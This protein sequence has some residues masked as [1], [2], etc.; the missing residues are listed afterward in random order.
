M[1]E[2]PFAVYRG[3]L[4][5]GDYPAAEFLQGFAMAM[6]AGGAF[7]MDAG[8]LRRLDDKHLQVF[9]EMASYFRRHGEGDPDFVDV[10]QAIKAKRAAHALFVKQR[11]DELRGSDPDAF[12]GGRHEHAQYLG[13]YER[14]HERNVDR[15]WYSPV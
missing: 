1:I 9:L 12:E 5:D 4:V 3:I 11:L 13:Q 6:Y 8:G 15:R 2:S 10:C 7:P 14:E